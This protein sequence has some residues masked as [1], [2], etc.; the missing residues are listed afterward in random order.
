MLSFLRL[1]TIFF[2]ME[3]PFKLHFSFGRC[4]PLVSSQ[5]VPGKN[6]IFLL[7]KI[8][9]GFLPLFSKT[10]PY[11]LVLYCTVLYCTVLLWGVLSCS[12]V[13]LCTAKYSLISRIKM[14]GQSCIPACFRLCFSLSHVACPFLLSM[15]LV[16]SVS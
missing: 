16:T 2:S 13:F 14:Q 7:S 3:D 12:T 8:L 10:F 11:G 4:A 1:N 9:H 5:T 15:L 6:W